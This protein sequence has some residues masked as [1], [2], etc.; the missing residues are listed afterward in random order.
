[1][2]GRPAE[3]IVT[4]HGAAGAVDGHVHV[5][6]PR[7]PFAEARS[8]TP[9]AATVDDLRAHLASL[10]VDRAVLVQPSV[11]GDDNR[12]LLDTLEQLG[13]TTARGIAVIDPATVTDD[14]LRTLRDAGVVGVRVNLHTKGEDRAQAVV[15]AV[16]QTAQRVA[17]FDMVVQIYADLALVAALEDTIAASPVPVVL[18]HFA[19]ARV[20]PGRSESNRAPPGHAALIRLLGDGRVWIKLSAPYRA[21]RQAPDYPELAPLARTLITTNPDRLVWASDWPHTGGGDERQGRKPTD[22]EPFR[23]V[24]D[25][26]TLALLAAWA[27]DDATRTKILV[28]NPARLF[29]F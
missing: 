25:A 12:A 23:Q 5:F 3:S 7:F 11:Y 2:I 19:G 13:P 18:D 29:R 6:D 16:A 9:P 22:I 20:E 15:A 1:M 24:D 26:R 14:Q 28:D 27:G 10:G 17:P 8:Y 4:R 21:A